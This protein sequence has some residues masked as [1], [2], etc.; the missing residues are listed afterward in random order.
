LASETFLFR[1]LPLLLFQHGGAFF[2]GKNDRFKAAKISGFVW[3]KLD[4]T[5]DVF[6]LVVKQFCFG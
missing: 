5:N 3:R 2:V 4:F 6:A 1:T